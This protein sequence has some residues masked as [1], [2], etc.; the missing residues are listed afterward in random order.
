[1]GWRR[2]FPPEN[3]VFTGN[4]VRPG[5]PG[6]KEREMQ[7]LKFFGMV[8]GKKTVL[9]IGGSLGARTINRSIEE[10]LDI[11]SDDIQLIWQTGKIYFDEINAKVEQNV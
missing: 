9:V 11:F 6:S 10:D 2:Y 1:M 3:I 8:P 4:P 7:G 5:I